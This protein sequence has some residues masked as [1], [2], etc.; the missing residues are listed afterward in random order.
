MRTWLP[1]LAVAALAWPSAAAAKE[2]HSVAVCGPSGCATLAAGP[3]LRQLAS[4]MGSQPHAV[5]DSVPLSHYYRV[6]I[7]IRGDHEIGHFRLFFV[8]PNLLRPAEG[9]GIDTPFNALPPAAARV[10]ASLAARIEP[11][12]APRVVEARIGSERVADPEPYGELFRTLP[13]TS[14]RGGAAS[15]RLVLTPDR[16]N[17]WFRKGRPLLYSPQGQI[18]ILDRA[19]RVPDELATEIARD[20]NLES[21][22]SSGVSWPGLAIVAVWLFFSTGWYISTRRRSSQA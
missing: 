13:A 14:G 6:D 9:D 21:A 18:L 8:Q 4:T 3:Q 16:A 15:L 1:A 2:I 22:A 20:A 10:L 19:L 7:R 11:Y 12:P 5:I 17:P